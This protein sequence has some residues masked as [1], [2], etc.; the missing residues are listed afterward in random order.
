[1]KTRQEIKA[2]AREALSYQRNTAIFIVLVITLLSFA[3]GIL[4]TAL[5][6]AVGAPIFWV[7]SIV[8][9]LFTL[10][11]GVNVYGQFINIY[12]HRPA[13]VGAVFTQL[14]VNFWR[15][16]GGN[17]WMALW[18]ML[19]TLLLIIPGIVKSFAYYFTPNILAD[20][21]NV[22]ATNALKISMRITQGYKLD[23]FIFALSWIGWM[24]LSVLT[25]GILYIVYVGPYWYTADAGL[26]V[27][28][29]NKAL[30]DGRITPADL[31]WQDDRPPPFAPGSPPRQLEMRDDYIM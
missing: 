9:G 7:V 10:V 31:G 25:L 23:V 18:L 26:Y 27:E 15:K 21:P 30:A 12:M 29:R 20:C 1:M 14:G 19:W 4:D 17:L 8:G 13:S 16:L 11:L 6:A 3:L 24:I 28:L 2:H 22:T 5:D